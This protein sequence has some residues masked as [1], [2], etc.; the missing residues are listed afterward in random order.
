M[1]V[2]AS[3][4][5]HGRAVAHVAAARGLRARIYLPARSS[6]VRRDAIAS[7]GADVVV[8]EGSYEDAVA[9]AAEQG[10]RPGVLEVADVGASRTAHW[11]I[12]GYSTL[13]GEIAA[14]ETFDVLLVPIGVGSLGAAAAR[15]GA[16]QGMHVLGVEPTSAACL[17]A[18]LATGA[19]TTVATPGTVM[20]GLD[21]AE[22]SVAA[23]PSLHR[24]IAGTVLV[25]DAEADAAV[26]ELERLGL[27]IG[28]SG[29]ATLAALR[30]LTA[31]DECADLRALVSFGSATRVVL[32]ATEGRT[33]LARVRR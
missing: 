17:T 30:L 16:Q 19:P 11:V 22:V 31:A 21:C 8:V 2:A 24:G 33:D 12:D 15:F 26:S 27:A 23:W 29:A 9:R 3:A 4:G 13:F 5:N 14:Q 18:S 10:A 28:A 32:I 1:L 6:E 25:T 7:E 20:A